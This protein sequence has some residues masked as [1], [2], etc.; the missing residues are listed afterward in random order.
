MK[1]R[2]LRDNPALPTQT[3]HAN[4]RWTT[5]ALLAGSAATLIP[6]IL[7]ATPCQH[8]SDGT[9]GASA[10]FDGPFFTVA[11]IFVGNFLGIAFE[12]RSQACARQQPSVVDDG[13]P[14]DPVSWRQWLQETAVI[15]V[16]GTGNWA[17]CLLQILSLIF[18]SA[19]SLAGMR[20]ALI[21][22]TAII[23]WRLY[24]KDSPGSQW[25]EWACIVATAVGAVAVGGADL[26]AARFYPDD[27]GDTS[28]GGSAAQVAVGLL[29]AVGGNACAAFQFGVEQV[30][31][32]RKPARYTKWR[33]LGTEGAW[34]LL[35]CIVALAALGS[36]TAAGPTSSAAMELDV[37]PAR[38]LS[39]PRLSIDGAGDD[40]GGTGN[41]W[42]VIPL[43]DPGRIFGCLAHTPA[44]LALAFSYV[45]SSFAFNAA[46]LQLT[47]DMGANYRVFVF[48]ARGLL[49]WAIETIIWY[50]GGD[51]PLPGA[52]AP[53]ATV[54]SVYGQRL[55]WCG[56]L[57]AAGFALLIGGGLYR[58][59]LQQARAAAAKREAAGE[60]G[61]NVQ[62]AESAAAPLLP[63]PD[64]PMRD[65]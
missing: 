6:R 19:A 37:A 36:R 10:A 61:A 47:G 65:E 58:L 48:T 52:S 57:T 42:P 23:S 32:E 21:L 63:P 8:S 25:L 62:A 39:S 24:L 15:L 13:R 29:L 50:A 40:G 4:V 34:G 38:G 43:D 20:G 55:T 14:L 56:L 28:N 44:T 60:V 12:L 17:A 35:L 53:G 7:L 9:Q 3:M 30:L 18:I 49:T 51:T 54:A 31:M 64:V 22:F 5:L 41:G 16:P 46:L 26:L 33:L 45:A 1:Q 11:L 59:H 2:E 27:G